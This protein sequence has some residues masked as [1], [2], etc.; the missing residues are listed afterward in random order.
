MLNGGG[1]LAS[2]LEA[3]RAN[4]ALKKG[5]GKGSDLCSQG[6]NF[7]YFLSLAASGGWTAP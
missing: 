1:G 5:V 4:V 2:K 7:N 3:T 6:L